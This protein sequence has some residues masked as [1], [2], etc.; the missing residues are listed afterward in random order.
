MFNL[1][2]HKNRNFPINCQILVV[3]YTGS[4]YKHPSWDRTDKKAISAVGSE[5]IFWVAK[6]MKWMAREGRV[7]VNLLCDQTS[8]QYPAPAVKKN[9]L[10]SP[11]DFSKFE[12]RFPGT[13]WHIDESVASSL[14]GNPVNFHR[15]E[16]STTLSPCMNVQARF[17]RRHPYGCG[18][19]LIR[20]RVLPEPPYR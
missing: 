17:S 8:Q 13:D 9:H 3:F 12:S 11:I 6:W 1:Y 2:R 7:F 19:L 10:E 20:F 16:D 18:V 14:Y 15:N 5:N 4:K